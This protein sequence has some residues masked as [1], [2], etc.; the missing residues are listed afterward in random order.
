MHGYTYFNIILHVYLFTQQVRF[1]QHK[2]YQDWFQRQVCLKENLKFNHYLIY[3]CVY[4]LPM[5]KL[6]F[7]ASCSESN[8]KLILGYIT[9][10]LHINVIDIKTKFNLFIYLSFLYRDFIS[11]GV[12][13]SLESLD[14]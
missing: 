9:Q 12:L 7:S 2:R 13:F 6:T 4:C 5:H 10:Q 11:S 1:G 3:I 14:T 8:I